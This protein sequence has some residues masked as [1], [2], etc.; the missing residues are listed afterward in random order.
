MPNIFRG[1]LQKA[2]VAWDE[3]SRQ[4]DE[5]LKRSRDKLKVKYEKLKCFNRLSKEQKYLL[6]GDN[7]F[8]F[9]PDGGAWF[10]NEGKLLAAFE[11][12]KQG[13]LGNAYE[14]WWDNAITAK[15]INKD[16][17]YVTFCSGK[18]ADTNECLDKLKRKA[19]IMMGS[20]YRFHLSPEGFTEQEI[21]DIMSRVLENFK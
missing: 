5:N 16:V 11:A 20:N 15:H 8:S 12:K 21:Y 14:R 10:D 13:K 3:K 2:G 19:E 18:G 17:V 6:V 9:A 1:G 4:L 7:C